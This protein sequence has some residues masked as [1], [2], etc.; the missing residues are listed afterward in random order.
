MV[1]E[2]DIYGVARLFVKEYG[3]D[4]LNEVREN[5]SKYIAVQDSFS[6]K[7][8]YEIEA[9]VQEIMHSSEVAEEI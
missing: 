8:W 6:L 9:A 7:K 1:Q 4:A 5:I 2:I 3:E